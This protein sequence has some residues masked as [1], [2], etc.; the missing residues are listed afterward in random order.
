LLMDK[1]NSR[2]PGVRTWVANAGISGHTTIDHLALVRNLP[3][4][5]QANMLVFLIGANDL[6]ATIAFEGAPTQRFLE[7][8]SRAMLESLRVGPAAPYPAYKHLRLFLLMR[9]VWHR[10][11]QSIDPPGIAEGPRGGHLVRLRAQRAAAGVL[12]LPDLQTG[13]NEYRERIQQIGRACREQSTRCLFLTQPSLLRNDLSPAEQGLLWFGNIG[14]LEKPK[15]YVT[16]GD[17]ANATDEYNRVLLATCREHSLECLDLAS[18]VPKDAALFYDDWHFNDS[19]AQVVSD[20]IARYLLSV[21]PFGA[22]TQAS[23]GGGR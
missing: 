16:P 17:L 3:V 18:A 5:R 15:G 20:N 8:R 21:P 19:G 6:N 12:P 14:R 1:L 10:V 2:Q 7:D 23:I 22:K 13:L 9:K 11:A 4:L